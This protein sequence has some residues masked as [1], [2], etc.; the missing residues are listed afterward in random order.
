[1]LL[2]PDPQ[3]YWPLLG[4]K[5]KTSFFLGPR[6]PGAGGNEALYKAVQ[7]L[8][9]KEWRNLDQT[10]ERMFS[11]LRAGEN[12]K[13]GIIK[14]PEDWQQHEKEL[15]GNLP[16]N[17]DELWTV[18]LAAAE[19]GSDL[20]SPQH[21]EG[22]KLSRMKMWC[23][24]L[25]SEKI[26]REEMRRGNSWGYNI[27]LVK[28]LEY[29]GAKSI[30][31]A[32]SLMEGASTQKEKEQSIYLV[33]VS[34]LLFVAACADADLDFAEG[35]SV[36]E[37][38]LPIVKD[39]VV[40]PPLRRWMKHAKQILG[41][42]TQ[43][44]T[45]NILLGFQS[46]GDSRDREG[47]RLWAF[48]G[49]YEPKKTKSKKLYLPSGDQFTK[50]VKAASDYVHVHNPENQQYVDQLKICSIFVSFLSNLYEWVEDLNSNQKRM[51]VFNDYPYFYQVA[52]NTKGPPPSVLGGG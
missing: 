30:Q 39:G 37:W 6:R 48:G 31:L 20:V 45:S 3:F 7:K 27:E 2:H 41:V 29:S 17:F 32:L 43:Q 13:Y 14:I 12:S 8:N 22:F 21:N 25:S 18:S 35:N 51:M 47:K 23:P 34:T 42:E 11:Y 1:M 26:W 52:R 36:F 40:V 24:Y 9:K 44:E 28:R 50:M 19:R 38:F 16:E 49:K 46:E 15:M 4:I 33:T 5:N 10:A